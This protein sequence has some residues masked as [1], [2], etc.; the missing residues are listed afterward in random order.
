M[1]IPLPHPVGNEVSLRAAIT[2][3]RTTRHFA[4]S[5]LDLLTV[6]ELLWA[7]QGR[8]GED[9]AR[10]APSAGAQ[11]P[12]ALFV[13]AGFDDDA[14]ARALRV[15]TGRS[16]SPP[17][18]WRSVPER[19]RRGFR[20][21]RTAVVRFP[22]RAP[23]GRVQP[24]PARSRRWRIVLR[25]ARSSPRC[26]RYGRRLWSTRVG[27][28][29]NVIVPPGRCRTAPPWNATCGPLLTSFASPLPVM[30]TSLRGA[31]PRRTRRRFA[32]HRTSRRVAPEHNVP[33]RDQGP[34]KVKRSAAS[35]GRAK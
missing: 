15:S 35:I 34:P 29:T 23:S 11:Y 26:A 20:A 5:A 31:R 3:R 28:A 12:L 9:G 16:S 24:G 6:S 10:T 32:Q 27:R 4:D 13:A 18:C 2:E 14:V 25:R 8:T 7:A 22:G 19:H 17:P 1:T 30:S 33:R 21:P